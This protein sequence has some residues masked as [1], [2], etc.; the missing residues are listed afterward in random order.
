MNIPELIPQD[1]QR[2]AKWSYDMDSSILFVL[3]HS[4][5]NAPKGKLYGYK[6]V[7][8]EQWDEAQ[9]A[10]SKGK[11]LIAEIINRQ[12]RHPYFLV[13]ESE[14]TVSTAA[15]PTTEVVIDIAPEFQAEPFRDDLVTE[16]KA[17]K[18]KPEAA[19]LTDMDL[20]P[21][22]IR[23]VQPV[24]SV[25]LVTLPEILPP[26]VSEGEKPFTQMMRERA[27][28]IR[29]AVPQAIA[30]GS[31]ELFKANGAA[32]VV[33]QTE[34]RAVVDALEILAR[35]LIDSKRMLDKFRNDVI[36]AYEA[37]EKRIEQALH[38]FRRQV[39]AQAKADAD[40]IRRENEARAV[41]AEAERRKAE[42][43]R[44][45]EEARIRKEEAQQAI[46]EAERQ[47]AAQ[48][49]TESVQGSLLGDHELSVADS[50]IEEAQ[51][52]IAEAEAEE[53]EANAFALA[54]I[55]ADEV[56]TP[57][58]AFAK[59]DL[60]V[61][62]LR[63]RAAKWVWE[64]LPSALRSRLVDGSPISRSHLKDP[65]SIPDNLWILDTKAVDAM[66]DSLKDRVN[67]TGIK[68]YDRNA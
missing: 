8:A 60:K 36:G 13:D 38:T 59:P 51:Q 27:F 12:D 31:E 56:Y 22:P 53:E 49:P 11:W 44:V 61:T 48:P 67:I 40:R 16:H 32:L 29:D 46:A 43:D 65:N 19:S 20:V 6:Q 17:P 66:V 57:P 26:D 35:P 54:P 50:V 52:A 9:E 45:A 4:T 10:E 55:H 3:F 30:I 15:K 64:F 42:A 62:G 23:E 34:R 2:F 39:E 18:A 1:S 41:A 5:K 14:F 33:I 24:P 47:K 7:A 58:V 68:A 28:A 37:S 63:K 21:E 25:A